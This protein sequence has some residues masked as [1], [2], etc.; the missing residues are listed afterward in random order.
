MGKKSRWTFRKRFKVGPININLSRSG[1]GG[2]IGTK[3]ARVGKDAKGRTYTHLSVP[4]TGVYKRQ[5]HDNEPDT[6]ETVTTNVPVEHRE[7]SKKK[8]SSCFVFLVAVLI[9]GL[10]C[11]GLMWV[12]AY[13]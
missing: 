4:K 9:V 12:I 6:I 11:I 7:P 10:A 2:S 13:V 3:G 5:Y 8:K 1:V